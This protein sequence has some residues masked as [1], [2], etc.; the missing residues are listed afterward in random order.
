MTRAWRVPA[1]FL[2]SLAL[3]LLL[4]LFDLTLF[5]FVINI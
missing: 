5:A 2:Q 4:C 1:C 3:L